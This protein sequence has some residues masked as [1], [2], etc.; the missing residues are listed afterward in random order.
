M[1]CPLDLKAGF[2]HT[3]LP[4]S[5]LPCGESSAAAY[6]Q[7]LAAA[8]L[9]CRRRPAPVAG[10]GKKFPEAAPEMLQYHLGVLAPGPLKQGL[11]PTI[12]E[13]V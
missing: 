13:S 11:M 2:L 12:G 1:L 4:A 10:L 9:S 5:S 7:S 6:M 3:F 8:S